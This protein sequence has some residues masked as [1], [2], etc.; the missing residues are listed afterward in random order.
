MRREMPG[1]RSRVGEFWSCTGGIW[2]AR[3]SYSIG[4]SVAGMMDSRAGF[5][6]TDPACRAPDKTTFSLIPTALL[7]VYRYTGLADRTVVPLVPY[8]KI[9]LS[10][11][12]WHITKDNGD[13]SSFN[14]QNAFGATLEARVRARRSG[15]GGPA[16]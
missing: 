1:F 13:T 9:G 2:L 5:A 16:D 6:A 14:G 10:Y 15:C 8:A 4:V 7:L 3:G 11:Y 12:I